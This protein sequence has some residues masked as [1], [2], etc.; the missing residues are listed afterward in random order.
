MARPFK[1]DIPFSV[2]LAR[3]VYA[4]LSFWPALGARFAL[5]HWISSPR[6]RESRREQN[7][8]G[9]AQTSFETIHGKSI[10]VYQWGNLQRGYVLLVHGWSGRAS[11][12]GALVES[13]NR[14]GVAVL[15]FDAP[16]HGRSQGS[17]S[18]IFQIENCAMALIEKY[19]V[20][21]SMIAHSFGCLVA[22]RLLRRHPLA[23][24]KLVTLSSPRKA[25]Y[26]V[27]GFQ[28]YFQISDRIMQRF[29][30]MNYRRYGENIYT[31]ISVEHNLRQIDVEL[32][33]V[34]DKSDRV[35][36]WEQT[37][38]LAR[39]LQISGK[40]VEVYYSTNGG[41]NFVL[42]QPDVIER[43]CTFICRD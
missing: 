24:K 3:K 30:A 40:V 37:R 7:W 8:R 41:H 21:D 18:D 25:S 20:P 2:R 9:R 33:L 42:R 5:R 23:T 32:L 36:G 43:V 12:F 29:H 17:T 6:F 38:S 27:L 35:V 22:A 34:H 15:G 31:D 28:T 39:D 11:Q 14:R 16:G 26:L 19:G 13:L 4:L 10:A 1:A